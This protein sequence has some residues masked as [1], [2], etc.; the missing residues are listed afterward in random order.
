M[1]QS[2]L[3]GVV[4]AASG[5][6]AGAGGPTL[7]A[8][9]EAIGPYEGVNASRMYIND[10][11]DVVASF[12]GTSV[13]TIWTRHRDG[14][15]FA[16]DTS[17]V[18]STL[19]GLNERGEFLFTTSRVTAPGTRLVTLS[20]WRP[21]AGLEVLAEGTGV[22]NAVRG[23]NDAGQT[24]ATGVN[25][26]PSYS[27]IAM[28]YQPGAGF[29]AL[30]GPGVQRF[31]YSVNQTGQTLMQFDYNSTQWASAVHTPGGDVRIV[32]HAGGAN[33]TGRA[34]NDRGDV[35]GYASVA[36]TSDHLAIV[37]F[38]GEASRMIGALAGHSVS[39]GEDINNERWVI[40]RSGNERPF[41]WTEAT[42]MLDLNWLLPDDS[43]WQLREVYDINNAG[44]IV[45]MAYREGVGHVP[46]VMSVTLVPSPGGALSAVVLAGMCAARRRRG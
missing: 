23:Y 14:T 43:G 44:Q 27:A 15:T 5:A 3:A 20:S 7:R 46:F 42:G 19:A 6:C 45:G 9:I 33:T 31:G 39:T 40:G 10:A 34:L 1:K 29:V 13:N 41:L 16:Y 35:V 38:E 18:N 22:P 24:A 37:A 2:V 26:Q 11:G 36:G 32:R 25:G 12:Y 21:G 17:G 8:T 30:P 28:Q 4:V